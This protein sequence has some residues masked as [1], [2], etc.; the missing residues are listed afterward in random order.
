[1]HDDANS[2]YDWNAYLVTYLGQS[3][4]PF[5]WGMWLNRLH[6]TIFR[7]NMVR[8]AALA[9]AAIESVDRKLENSSSTK[10]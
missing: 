5:V 10:E 4:S 1:M 8:V 7:E 9:V 6:L 2:P 3:I